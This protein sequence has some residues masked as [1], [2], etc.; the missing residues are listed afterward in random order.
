MIYEYA[1]EPALVARWAKDGIAGLAGQFGLDQRRVVS[2]LPTYWQGEV[3]AALLEE[4]EYDAGHPGYVEASAFLSAILE[5]MTANVVSRGIGFQQNRPWLEQTL[6]THAQEP[7]HAILARSPVQDQPAV[8][9]D[10]IVDQLRDERWY[11]PTVRPVPKTAP[12]LA[13]VLATL[14]RGATKIVVVDP[15]FDPRDPT[16]Q[17]VLA[18]LLEGA[19]ALRGPGRTKPH[20]ELIVGVGEGRPNGGS[21]PIAVQLENAARNQ[22]A[23]AVQHLAPSIPRGMQLI[24]RCVANFLDGDRLHNRFVLT[25]FAGASLPYGTQALGPLVFDDLSLLYKGQYEERWRQFTRPDRLN[26]I[27]AAQVVIGTA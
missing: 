12:D 17:S 10:D 9:T 20:V 27:G 11:L 8:V 13:S 15:Y 16:Y 7:F 14:L 26:P 21:L 22:C 25:D 19:A 6:A 2:D 23:W 5:F 1:V 3:A 18:A 24:F 4:F